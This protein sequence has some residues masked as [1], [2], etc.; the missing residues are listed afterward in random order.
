MSQQTGPPTQDRRSDC[1]LVGR[2]DREPEVPSGSVEVLWVAGTP[3][4]RE[5]RLCQAATYSDF[6]TGSRTFASDDRGGF[7]ATLG[8]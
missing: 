1:D 8:L 6:H 2:V 4:M 5:S 3:G 7:G